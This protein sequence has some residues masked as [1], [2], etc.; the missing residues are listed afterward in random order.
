MKIRTVFTFVTLSSTLALAACSGGQTTSPEPTTQQSAAATTRAPVAVSSHGFVKLFGEAL[1]DV[2]LRADQRTE[3]EKLA[4]DA[5]ARHEAAR[6]AHTAIGAEL[7][8]QV[9]KGTLDR[10][11]LQAKLDAAAAEM[12]KSRPA[13]RAAFQ[14]LHDILDASQRTAFV[15]AL[16]AKMHDKGAAMHEKDHK[17]GPQG[18][19]AWADELK[20]TDAQRDQIKDKMR[21]EFKKAHASGEQPDFAKMREHHEHGG[22]VLD[23]FKADNFKIDEVAPPG[24]AKAHAREMSDRM[25]KMVEIALP[26]LTPE[27]RTIAA[28]KIRERGDAIVAPAPMAPPI[29]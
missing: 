26:I 8:A 16:K 18:M 6:K 11:A 24:D 13:D 9:E 28:Q 4:A 27:Q 14:R 2:P 10:T 19:H 20:L 1:G 5:D 7:A 17:G 29:H 21:E 3:I 23:A 12:D 25:F 22:K 15:D